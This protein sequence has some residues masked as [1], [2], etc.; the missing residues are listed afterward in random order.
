MKKEDW[1]KTMEYV[2]N[3][4]EVHYLLS[5]F[6]PH[7][8]QTGYWKSLQSGKSNGH[9]QKKSLKNSLFSLAKGKGKT[10]TTENI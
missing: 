9:R 8:S 6:F 2:K 5:F 10:N 1:A 7:T 3:N 4:M